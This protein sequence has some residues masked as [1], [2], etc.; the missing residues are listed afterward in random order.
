MTTPRQETGGPDRTPRSE[1]ESVRRGNRK[2]EPVLLV[3]LSTSMDWGIEDENDKTQEWPSPQSRRAV[4]IAALPLLV[5]ALADMDT[6]A[7]HEQAGGSDEMG[8]LL[9]FGFAN[10]P[11]EIGDL[12]LSNL[13]RRLNS[14]RWG[15]GTNV[16]PAMKLA[17][18]EYNDEFEDDEDD[19][20]V[21]LILIVTDGAASDWR[22]LEPYLM[23]ANANRVFVIAIVGHGGPAASTYAEYK[24]VAEK[25]QAADKHGKAHVHVVS[26]DGVSDPT[27]IGE[28][29]VTLAT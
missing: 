1:I 22:E 28:D 20:R 9:T 14:I 13:D 3:D 4:V 11:V 10:Q 7:E 15:G 19:S 17:L 23:D 2:Y 24:Q 21:H 8:G 5:K 27:E 25:N 12:N 16:V 26:F 29:L 18:K 6:E